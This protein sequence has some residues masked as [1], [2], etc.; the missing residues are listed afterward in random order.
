MTPTSDRDVYL[1]TSDDADPILIGHVCYHLCGG[2]LLPLLQNPLLRSRS[3]E[4]WV[5][6]IS[7]PVLYKSVI[8]GK[9]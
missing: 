8:L 9:R 3:I 1:V 2:P 5:S 7:V 4:Y 6:G